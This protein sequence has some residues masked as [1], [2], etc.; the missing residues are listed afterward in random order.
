MLDKTIISERGRRSC[1]GLSAC[2]IMELSSI[3]ATGCLLVKN[4][5]PKYL[6]YYFL[7]Y[8][9]QSGKTA[10]GI[11]GLAGLPVQDGIAPIFPN[12]FTTRLMGASPRRPSIVSLSDEYT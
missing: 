12:E 11:M 1:T 4:N 10:S 2:P 9:R 6:F 3:G 7:L 8:D 5:F